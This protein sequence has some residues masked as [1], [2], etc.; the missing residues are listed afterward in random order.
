MIVLLMVILIKAVQGIFQ[1]MFLSSILLNLK[2]PDLPELNAAHRYPVAES[3]FV[4]EAYCLMWRL[5]MLHF[6]KLVFH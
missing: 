5:L 4:D 6:L 2:L 3:C 1:R